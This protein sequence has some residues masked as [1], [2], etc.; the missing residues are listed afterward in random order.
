VSTPPLA[1]LKVLDLAWVVAGPLI[2]RALADFGATV[3]R[4]ESSRRIETARL[5]GP[6]PHGRMDPQQSVLYENCNAN[7]L[8]LTLDLSQEQGRQVARDLARWA[9]VVVES[10]MPG[11][12]KRFGLDY[13]ALREL[14]P[15]LIMVSTALMGQTGPHAQMTGFGNVGAALA[16][17]QML[18]GDAGELPVGPFGPYTDYVGPRFG[19][20]AL[21]AALDH[22]ERTGEGCFLDV[23][24]AEA[25]VT[26]L[27]PQIAEYSATGRV[28]EPQGNRD[29][30]YA[31]H[32]VFRTSGDDAWVAIAARGDDEWR[33]LAG[34]IGGSALAA[35]ERF[36]TLA[37]RKRHEDEL[38]ALVGAWAAKRGACEIEARLQGLGVAA[39]AVVGS[40]DFVHDP[41]LHAR[42][43]FVRLPHPLM[44]ESVFESARY[45]LEDTPAAYVRT[46]PTFGRDADEVLGHV[47]GYDD[48]KVEDLRARGIL[49]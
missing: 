6:F 37:E 41:Q 26:F 15:G 44:G 2:G 43:H 1:G 3:V 14:N 47:L 30:D 23:A 4:V 12:M 22:R 24:Q 5:M 20:F 38:E 34:V 49:Q 29:P 10:F 9:D 7:K 45:R 31:P 39:H 35:D 13:P 36:A 11:Q 40:E 33:T 8:G 25:G 46:A 19:L 48:A 16:G 42:G 32:G 21:L 28:V 27:A 17:F 18:V